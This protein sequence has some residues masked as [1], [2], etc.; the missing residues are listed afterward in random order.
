MQ[1]F[2]SPRNLDAILIDPREKQSKLITRMNGRRMKLLGDLF[3]LA[4]AYNEAVN[5]YG[6]NVH[7]FI[8]Q[9]CGCS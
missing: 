6:D 5:W 4:G 8:S 7:L 1:S 3:L 9:S 2:P